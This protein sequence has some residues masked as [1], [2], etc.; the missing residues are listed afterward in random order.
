MANL[1]E[2]LKIQQEINAVIKKRSVMLKE[3]ASQLTGQAKLAKE[4]CKALDCKD[5]DNME[6]RLR[7]VNEELKRAAENAQAA[8][9]E[10]GAMG[11]AAAEAE[12]K[13]GGL[14]GKLTAIGGAI[15]GI[16]GVATA[17]KGFFGILKGAG[18]LLGSIVGGIFSIGKAIISIPFGIFSGLLGMAQQGGGGP[19][20]I[21]L[22]LEE[23]RDA[24]GSLATNEGK[25]L[26]DIF[27]P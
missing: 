18:K 20:P 26:K 25:A 13:A 11:D 15:G 22:Q 2:Q 23:I 8:E 4:L 24:V 10:I 16:S 5:L 7:G 12:S 9:D 17:F 19:S 1:N 14:S 3:Q 6:E 27:R 21:R